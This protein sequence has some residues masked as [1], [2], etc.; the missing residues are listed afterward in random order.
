MLLSR[1]GAVGLAVLGILA[2]VYSLVGSWNVWVTI[3]LTALT[4]VLV[5]L[6]IRPDRA[7]NKVA[8]NE[9]KGTAFVRGSADGS[10]FRDIR[11]NADDFVGGSA[12]K[13]GF[14][15]VDHSPVASPRRNWWRIGR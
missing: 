12:R 4:V 10:N 2:S 6:A 1:I 11:S 3:G 13:A 5:V 7:R 8:A 9:V 14:E 15:S